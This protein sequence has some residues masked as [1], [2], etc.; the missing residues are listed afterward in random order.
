MFPKK[1]TLQYDLGGSYGLAIN[2]KLLSLSLIVNKY[3]LKIICDD[4][5]EGYLNFQ[6]I[7]MHFHEYR[8]I[9]MRSFIM[10]KYEKDVSEQ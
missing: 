4:A 10:N 5:G 8:F 2:F 1:A 7:T 6:N 3:R 9:M